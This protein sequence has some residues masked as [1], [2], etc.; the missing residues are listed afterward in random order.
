MASRHIVTEEVYLYPYMNTVNLTFRGPRIVIYSDIM[1]ASEMH[2]FSNLFDKVLYM[3]RTC[4][5]EILLIT[6]S[7]HVQNMYST[8]SNKFEKYRISLAS[9]IRI[10]TNT[11][12]DEGGGSVAHPHQLYPQASKL[13]PN[14]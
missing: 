3:F 8:L 4:S 12:L 14:V 11:A 6:D 5:V 7:G 2:C 10:T 9:I 13:V 1:K